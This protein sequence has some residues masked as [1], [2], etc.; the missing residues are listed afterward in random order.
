MEDD[1]GEVE[2][3]GVVPPGQ[4]VVDL[5]GQGHEGAVRLVGAGVRKGRSPEVVG[6]EVR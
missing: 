6:Q 2:D 1:V 4:E 5:E 3:E